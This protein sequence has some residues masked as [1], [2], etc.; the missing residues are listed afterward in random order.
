MKYRLRRWWVVGLFL[1]LSPVVFSSDLALIS[2]GSESQAELSRQVCGNAFLRQGERFLVSLTPEAAALLV[3]AGVDVSV[4][5]AATDPADLALV[6][7]DPVRSS[8]NLDLARY[9]RTTLLD[10]GGLLVSVGPSGVAAFQAE[11]G[12]KVTPLI[13]WQTSIEYYQPRAY[14]KLAAATYPTDSL[15]N[16]INMDTLT[17]LDQRLEAFYTRR[18]GSDS[19]D[20]ARDWLVQKF[21]S[22]GYT[23]VTT[24][25]FS[26]GGGTHYNVQ[27]IKTGHAEPNSYIVIGGH[28]DSFNAQ[29]PGSVF[30]PGA[31]D[32]ASGTALTLE[33]ARV[34]RNIPTRKSLIFIPFSAEEV[35]LY[36]SKAAADGFKSA[37]TN[38]ECMFNFDMVA[39]V[40]DATWWLNL[41]SGP[42]TAYREITADAASRL[43]SIVPYITGLGS[44]SDHWP[45]YQHGFD[46]VDHI[47]HNFNTA[48]WHTN[49]DV[50]SRLNFPYFTEV[51]KLAIA[52]V[53]ITA[54]AGKPGKIDHIVDNGDGSSVTVYVAGCNPSS[55]YWIFHGSESGV[56]TDSV[57]VPGGSCSVV[58]GGLPEGVPRYFGVVEA[59]SDGYRSIW[60]TQA[61]ETPFLH[62]RPPQGLTAI[63]E[64]TQI[65]L[66]W[67]HNLE[68]DVDHY[69]VYRKVEGIGEWMA[70]VD[71]LTDTFFVD[72]HLQPQIPYLYA[73]VAIDHDGFESAISGDIKSYAAT[74][75][76][77]ILV[78]DEFTQENVNHPD[79]SHQEAWL[80][81]I[82]GETPWALV[83]LDA[84]SGGLTRNHVARFSSV[85]WNDDDEVKKMLTASSDPVIWF[86]NHPTNMLL[87]GRRT[88][89]GVT[90]SP[91]PADHYLQTQFGLT[92]YSQ[93]APDFTGAKG[94][95]G[96]PS[97]ELGPPPKMQYLN[98]VEKL[99]GVPGTT[100]IYRWDADPD[101]PNNEEDPVGLAWDSPNGKR[102]LLSFP[103]YNLTPASAQALIAKAV[104]YFNE[105]STGP[106]YGDVDMSG[107]V[108]IS[109]LSVLID[110]LFISMT[111]PP[112]MSAADIDQS[113]NVDIS[114]V[115]WLIGY[116]FL[117]G[118]A[119]LPPCAP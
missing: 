43:T 105:G 117:G 55:T 60:S 17:A 35:G 95:N 34:F 74:F 32:D 28:Y 86:L 69:A 119:P 88:I 26:Y 25:A 108:D 70:V 53:A 87:S 76:G 38:V 11:T 23:Q 54:N 77:G 107:N 101:D 36:G 83:D 100:V 61:T 66:S 21:Q 62:P 56:L 85:F 118:P 106:T 94:Q 115:G 52:S 81:T 16:L 111:S 91:V 14:F 72:T 109:D 73:I 112:D 71:N 114:D 10:D 116:L 110:Y 45:F 40:T 99:T 37:G 93:V 29:S 2:V 44:S 80:D 1:V 3:S 96:W 7:P 82:L 59:P 67:R 19:I 33:L 103:L 98:W 92:G 22:W 30:A 13:D 8:A 48:G 65:S 89:P 104:E 79:Q 41:S 51:A 42:N 4:I 15:A 102:V 68:A 57:L 27:A 97:V 84:A 46:I 6:L 50:S 18:V 63:P 12:L 5:L 58:V 39:F 49:L 47:E 64:A 24:P 90:T 75:D 31:D 78:V 113:C 20:R 9:G